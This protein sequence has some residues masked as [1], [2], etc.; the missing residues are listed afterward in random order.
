M[1]LMMKVLSITVLVQCY[2]EN[3]DF[4]LGKVTFYCITDPFALFGGTFGFIVFKL[5]VVNNTHKI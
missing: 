1:T 3:D 5:S 4:F 2:D